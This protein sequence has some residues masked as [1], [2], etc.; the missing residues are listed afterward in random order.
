MDVCC[1]GLSHHTA[2]LAIREKLALPED[3]RIEVLKRVAKDGVEA[4]LVSTCNRV[5]LYVAAGDGGTMKPVLRDEIC[6]IAGQE[7]LAHAYEH[8]GDGAL[9]HLFRVACSLDSMVLGEPQI[10]GQ[11]KDALE[12][13]QKTG[14]ARGELT[15]ACAAAF[16]TAKRVRSE[17]AIGRA[18]VS[19]ASAAVELAQKIF[20]SLGGK[21]VLVV[22][23]GEMAE[24][25]ARHLSHAGAAKIVV[26]NR[27]L[28]KAESLA[29]EVGGVARPFEEMGELL[30]AADVVVTCT[31]SPVPIFTRA[32]VGAAGKPRKH[33]PLFF[34]DLA[35]PRDVDPEVGTLDGVY[36]YD[37][38]DL[39]KVVAEN[40]AA[41]A[42]EAAKAEVIVAEEVARFARARAQR[43]GVPVLAL[44]RKHAERIARAESERTLQAIGAALSD[45]QR[46]SVEA[47]A[48]A[49]V[50]KLL[51]Q[52]TAKLRSSGGEDDRL[53]EAAAELFGLE[54]PSEPV[55][56][57]AAAGGAKR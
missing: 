52:P 43:D 13:A 2:P 46:K 25:A 33:R 29:A 53:A 31:A 10:L 39:Q 21:V 38:D 42:A 26:A 19:M 7:A 48:M 3:R 36:A 11:V 6:R 5:E 1:I 12:L 15:R 50:N 28:S 44:L 4:V 54:A 23:A 35:V 27:T 45:K 41:R 22:G 47:M 40:A 37:V 18:A 57:A 30:V 55:P 14:T 56:A 51:H 20:G 9:I 17:T 16:S 34:V 24:L 32:S 8:H 49:I